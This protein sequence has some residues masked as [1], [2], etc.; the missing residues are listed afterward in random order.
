MSWTVRAQK[1]HQQP[2]NPNLTPPPVQALNLAIFNNLE[3]K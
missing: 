2:S 3:L 1:K